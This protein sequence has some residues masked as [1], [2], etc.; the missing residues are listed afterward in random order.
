MARFPAVAVRWCHRFTLRPQATAHPFFEGVQYMMAGAAH[1]SVLDFGQSQWQRHLQSL[2]DHY[3]SCRTA[4]SL[5]VVPALEAALVA[6]LQAPPQPADA[7]LRPTRPL[8]HHSLPTRQGL[9]M[10]RARRDPRHPMNPQQTRPFEQRTLFS[11]A[12][13]VAN[14]RPSARAST[15]SPTMERLS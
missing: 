12:P 6:A 2:F 8:P 4:E 15:R 9:A 1:A 13:T 3:V 14:P 5:E 7:T 11:L 10:R